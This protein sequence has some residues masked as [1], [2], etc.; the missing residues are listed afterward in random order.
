MECLQSKAFML[1]HTRPE[2]VGLHKHHKQSKAANQGFK[3]C[4]LSQ[5]IAAGHAH[6]AS[7]KSLLP[8][9]IH[10]QCI[11]C[12]V[13]VITTSCHPQPVQFCIIRV[14]T[15]VITYGC[16]LRPCL[17]HSGIILL[18]SCIAAL[19][20][21]S[22]HIS[23]AS[24]HLHIPLTMHPH[25]PPGAS[26]HA[27][28]MCLP[29]VRFR[30]LDRFP[31][32]STVK[33]RFGMRSRRSAFKCTL[34]IV[35]RRALGSVQMLAG[36]MSRRLAGLSPC[37]ALQMR[38]GMMFRRSAFISWPIFMILTNSGKILMSKRSFSKKSRALPM[39]RMA[40]VTASAPMPSTYTRL[41]SRTL[42]E[43]APA[44]GT[45]F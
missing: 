29:G 43:M 13:R 8:A 10:N 15:E 16:H 11:F 1:K 7:S 25:A 2:A 24:T 19:S 35:S 23:G 41:F 4:T 32:C 30:R 36:M 28:C 5:I 40:L 9:A 17:P 45:I 27:L 31:P 42:L 22:K 21:T 3:Y 26:H 34:E 6:S 37:N 12:V 14:I 18:P 44:R 33:M 20:A 39:P 38:S